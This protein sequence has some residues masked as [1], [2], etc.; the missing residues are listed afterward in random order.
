MNVRSSMADNTKPALKPHIVEITVV[1]RVDAET[2][3]KAHDIGREK[4]E[5][6][7]AALSTNNT[8]PR[9][10]VLDKVYDVAGQS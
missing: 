1:Y 9:D 8:R 5:L 3:D 4:R 6:I 10:V 7:R 2:W